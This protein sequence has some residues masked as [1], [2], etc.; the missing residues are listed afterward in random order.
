MSKLVGVT[1][2][3][4]EL[5]DQLL[6]VS[7]IPATIHCPVTEFT[8]N[9]MKLFHMLNLVGWLTPWDFCG[10]M[11]WLTDSADSRNVHISSDSKLVLGCNLHC[12]SL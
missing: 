1:A 3:A 4:P 2:G 9:V 5:H 11:E 8:F 7:L 10:M 6:N 12:L